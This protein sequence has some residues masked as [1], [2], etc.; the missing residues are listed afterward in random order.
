MGPPTPPKPPPDALER[1]IGQALAQ[2]PP[3]SIL[4]DDRESYRLLAWAGTARPFLLPA[5]AGFT[6]ALSA[7]SLYVDRVLVCRGPGALYRRYGE[8]DLPGFREVWRYKGCRLLEQR[9]S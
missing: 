2:A 8:H 6:L 4:A 1:A 5:D 9:P 3:R 7:P